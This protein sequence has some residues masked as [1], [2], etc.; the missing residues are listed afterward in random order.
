MH[1]HLIK[2]TKVSRTQL[3]IVK[4]PLWGFGG[5]AGGYDERVL[6]NSLQQWQASL[7]VNIIISIIT[8]ERTL[9]VWNMMLISKV[10]NFP[11]S[12]VVLNFCI[13]N[14]QCVILGKKTTSLFVLKWEQLQVSH[15]YKKATYLLS[16]PVVGRISWG[17]TGGC[18]RIGWL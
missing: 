2:T 13:W 8:D 16:L 1:P 3:P 10:Y 4:L 6:N 11:Q 17:T 9:S 18:T 15:T 14:K 12:K 5:R 7:I